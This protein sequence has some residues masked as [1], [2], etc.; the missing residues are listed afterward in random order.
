MFNFLCDAKAIVKGSRNFSSISGTFWF[1]K[2]KG[3][4]LVTA[5]VSG[6]P[7]SNRPCD[8][9]IFATHIHQK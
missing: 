4:V 6:L 8:H 7:T 1:R 3:G 5:K 2:V 9:R